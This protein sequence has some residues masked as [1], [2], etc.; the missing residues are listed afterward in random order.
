MRMLMVWRA[1]VVTLAL[2]TSGWG[3]AAAEP[4]T[5]QTA[6]GEAS[7]SERDRSALARFEAPRL[8]EAEAAAAPDVPATRLGRLPFAEVLAATDTPG[9][10]LAYF[11]DGT[12]TWTRAWGVSDAESGEPV[13]DRTLFQAASISKPVAAA[14][15][16]VGA[17]RG[18]ITLDAPVNQQLRS[19]QLPENELTRRRAVTPRLL[20]CHAGG[21]TVHGFPGY[22]PTTTLPTVPNVLD[23]AGGANTP[24][25][26]VDLEPGVKERYSGG[27]ITILQLLL[28]EVAGKSF[29]DVLEEWVLRP[30]GMTD[31]AFDQPP[32][33]DR[34]GRAARAH[35]AKG[36]TAGARWH[37]YPELAAAGLWTTPRDLALFALEIVRARRGEESRILHPSYARLMTE[38]A[39][40]GTFALGF[41]M[42]DR[43]DELGE[44]WYF[45]HSG[46]NW[47]FRSL[48]LVDREQGHGFAAMVNGSSFDVLLELQRRLARVY[49][50]KGDFTKPPRSWPA[51]AP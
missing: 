31:S 19:W 35:L 18:L 13:T 9:L 7:L 36:A 24:A 4:A 48:L 1:I 3:F 16:L 29:P 34:A 39:G 45:G 32:L 33:P 51:Q 46:G 11:R 38:P 44:V 21:T 37:V 30:I 6:T 27:G 40:I 8:T 25:V 28:T 15:I 23:G 17:Q 41:E 42:Q 20:L 10:S 12:V 2:S 47:G 22:E 50:W 49:E 5:A 14:A 43:S 26:R